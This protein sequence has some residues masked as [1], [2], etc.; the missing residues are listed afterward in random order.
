MA[1]RRQFTDRTLLE[2]MYRLLLG[3]SELVGT[4]RV[5]LPYIHVQVVAYPT[6]S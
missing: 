2:T 4:A 5:Q 6:Q 3:F 1:H